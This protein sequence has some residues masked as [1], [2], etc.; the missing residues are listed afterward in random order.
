MEEANAGLEAS[1]AEGTLVARSEVSVSLEL[2]TP[3]G[4]VIEELQALLRSHSEH[5]RRSLHRWLEQDEGILA[6][7]GLME[8]RSRRERSVSRLRVAAKISG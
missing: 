4:L 2:H 6:R 5:E 1:A 8:I 3:K 7:R